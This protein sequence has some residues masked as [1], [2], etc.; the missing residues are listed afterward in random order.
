MWLLELTV[1]TTKPKNL[2]NYYVIWPHHK[3]KDADE[4]LHL[5]MLTLINTSEKYFSETY[6]MQKFNILASLC[7]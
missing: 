7:S 3:K 5:L 4:P 2:G 6:N 1:L